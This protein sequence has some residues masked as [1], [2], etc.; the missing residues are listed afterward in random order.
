MSYDY[1]TC[2]FCKAT[3]DPHRTPKGKSID[4]AEVGWCRTCNKPR[5]WNC[6]GCGGAC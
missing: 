3:L 5:C 4:Y 1:G 6:G 2:P